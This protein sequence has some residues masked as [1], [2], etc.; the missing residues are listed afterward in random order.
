MNGKSE[1]A[2]ESGVRGSGRPT[3]SNFQKPLKDNE[4]TEHCNLVV[5]MVFSKPRKPDKLFFKQVHELLNWS[6]TRFED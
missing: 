4:L 2:R 5:T 6:H 3:P 1:S